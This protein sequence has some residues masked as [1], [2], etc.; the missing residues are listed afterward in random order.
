VR[1][2]T[3]TTQSLCVTTPLI[4]KPPI[5][6]IHLL[7]VPSYVLSILI[8]NFQHMNI[9]KLIFTN[10]Y[11]KRPLLGYRFFCPLEAKPSDTP[12]LCYKLHQFVILHTFHSSFRFQ[13]TRPRNRRE[14]SCIKS[15]FEY[16]INWTYHEHMHQ[17]SVS[18]NCKQ[19]FTSISV[20]I[21]SG[22]KNPNLEEY[23]LN[24]IYFSF[25]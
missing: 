18:W 25:I 2:G 1:V 9:I 3:S 11:A 20:G 4:T 14:V 10:K 24:E 16:V 19:C 13:Q 6:F 22:H 5:L 8:S 12:V 15:L 23:S 17:F 21:S 7:L